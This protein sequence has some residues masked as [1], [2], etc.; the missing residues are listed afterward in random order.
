MKT[1]KSTVNQRIMML[2]SS[3]NVGQTQFCQMAQIST[4]T[5]HNIRKDEVELK[6]RTVK[7]ICARLNASEKFVFEGIEPMFNQEATVVPIQDNTWKDKA[8]EKLEAT[9]TYLQ[10]KLDEAMATIA[11]LAQRIP[12]GKSKALFGNTG[13][14][15]TA[16]GSERAAA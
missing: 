9:N 3:L 11:I 7:D 13:S 12:L 4:S 1:A 16:A 5:Y 6:P 14:A 8:F 15:A 2:K 10:A